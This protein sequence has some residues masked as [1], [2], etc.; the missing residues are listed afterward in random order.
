MSLEDKFKLDVEYPAVTLS[1]TPACIPRKLSH[2]VVP[3]FAVMQT[4]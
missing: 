2:A 1:V 3:S 4:Q